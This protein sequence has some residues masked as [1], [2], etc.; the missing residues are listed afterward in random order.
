MATHG[1]ARAAGGPATSRGRRL[2]AR[3][4]AG[5]AVGHSRA[6]LGGWRWLGLLGLVL[7]ALGCRGAAPTASQP[8]PAAAAPAGGA[9]RGSGS[10]PAPAA[11]GPA[12][13]PTSAPQPIV[14]AVPVKSLNFLPLY[15]GQDAGLFGEEGFDLTIE[16]MPAEVSM[17]GL[18]SG[19]LD[20]SAAGTAAIRAAVSGAPVRAL[21]FMSIQ[22]TFYI[23]SKPTIHSL[24]DLRQKIVATSSLGSSTTEVARLAVRRAGLDPQADLQILATGATANAYK[25]LV[26][27]Q[28]D[29]AVLSVPFN[30]QAERDGYYPLLYAGDVTSSPESGLSAS[31][32]RLR[33]E[34]DEVRRMLRG[35]LRS[36]RYV[37][38]HKAETTE[39]IA[40]DFGVDEGLAEGAYDTMVRAYSTDGD[41]DASAIEELIRIQRTEQGQA[42]EITVEDVTDYGP[43]HQAQRDLGLR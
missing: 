10:A 7:A 6:G 20:Y 30:V 24:T 34:P 22:P 16:V 36:L 1:H 23:M 2:G 28:A 25:A 15:V 40:R 38:E 33:D 5:L 32:D 17:A 13:A 43:L 9:D 29:A 39:R 18:V 14:L 41:I 12:A 19:S 37:R 8:A 21:G 42:R 26:S 4:G 31:L 3:G 35:M 11:S 27:G